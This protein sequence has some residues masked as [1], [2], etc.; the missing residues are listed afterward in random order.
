MTCRRR[1]VRSFETG[2]RSRGSWR[3]SPCAMA[4]TPRRCTRN[5][6]NKACISAYRRKHHELPQDHP[7]RRR[8]RG[9]RIDLFGGRHG[10]HGPARERPSHRHVRARL[11]WPCEDHQRDRLTMHSYSSI[12][13]LG[14]RAAQDILKGPVVVQEKIDGSQFSFQA[15]D[16]D[17]PG[18]QGTGV[19]MKS[20]GAQLFAETTDKLFRPAVDTVMGLLAEDRL[21]PGWTYR[22]E[23]LAKPK[24]NTLAYDRVP[25]GNII[26]F[27]IDIGEESYVLPSYLARYAQE[28]GLE[29]VPMFFEG[30]VTSLEQVHGFLD[31]V[32]VL[33]GTKIEGV[34]LKAYGKYGPDKKT[35]MAKYVSERFK[36]IHQG[37]WKDRNPGRADILQQQIDRYKTPARWQKAV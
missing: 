1:P 20:K 14:H 12:Y 18:P 28:L 30:M 5:F 34:V 11:D 16:I 29:S 32:S 25:A 10:R 26:L 21:V 3:R 7:C 23:V 35:L 33:G 19:I 15:V 37:D 24:H 22:G 9:R 13:N 4:L 31:T 17:T 6:V 36:E 2:S 27:D 8:G